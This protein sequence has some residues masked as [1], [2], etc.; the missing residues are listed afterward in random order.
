MFEFL[1]IGYFVVLKI[2]VFFRR[3]IVY[4]IIYDMLIYFCIGKIF[5]EFLKF[6]VKGLLL[7]LRCVI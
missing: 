4:F 6:F 7:I 2:I 5:M 3:G 1:G